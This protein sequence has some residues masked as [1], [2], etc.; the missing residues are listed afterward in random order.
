MHQAENDVPDG[1]QSQ[2]HLVTQT[3][4][5]QVNKNGSMRGRG[6]VKDKHT[7]KFHRTVR[8]DE[9]TYRD[10]VA[11]GEPYSESVLIDVNPCI[12]QGPA[13]SRQ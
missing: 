4:E 7:F 6:R 11:L 12:C 13:I 9:T 2:L 1:N 3:C 5:R 10:T 8:S